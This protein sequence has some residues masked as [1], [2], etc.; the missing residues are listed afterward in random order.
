VTLLGFLLACL[1]GVWLIRRLVRYLGWPLSGQA[2]G[3][4]VFALLVSAVLLRALP[5]LPIKLFRLPAW[6]V[7]PDGCLMAAVGG[8]GALALVGW[9]SWRSRSEPSRRSAHPDRF[10]VRRR[11]LPPPPH[12]AMDATGENPAAHNQQHDV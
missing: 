10:L 5:E 7:G 4:W 11:A 2:V 6:D 1:L 12:G 9:I 8:F 3:R